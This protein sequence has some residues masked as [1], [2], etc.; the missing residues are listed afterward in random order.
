MLFPRVHFRG[1]ML[2]G[3]PPG[4]LGLANKTGRMNSELFSEVIDHFIHHSKSS[5]DQTSLLVYDNHES[6]LSIEVMDKAKENGVT[7][8]T[9][10]PHSSN[11]MQ[12]LDV[13]VYK[14]FKTYYSQAMDSWMMRN[15]GKP[16]SIY[17]I[18]HCVGIA[19]QKAMTPANITAA[20]RKTGIFPF[21][22][23]IFTEA[24]FLSTA[25]TDRPAPS[26]DDGA[27][28]MPTAVYVAPAG[29]VIPQSNTS[30]SDPI[31]STSNPSTS[32]SN[33]STSTSDPI[34]SASDPSKSTPDN[35]L[36][37]QIFNSPTVFKGYPKAMERKSTGKGRRKGSSL[38]AT[39]TPVKDALEKIR[40]KSKR[41]KPKQSKRSLVLE[42][43]H[44]SEHSD[45]SPQQA[46][47]ARLPKRTK[48]VTNPSKGKSKS[49]VKKPR[50][51]SSSSDDEKWPCIICGEPF[52]DSKSREV[53]V[54]CQLC[55]KIGTRG[56]HPR[57]VFLHLP[58][59]WQREWLSVG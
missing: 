8:L 7:I 20:F 11:K 45:T 15:P 55:K 54:D 34:T 16:I 38:I 29:N 14:P 41:T 46:P 52:E 5:K 33:P 17:E 28:A 32:T 22:K 58:E 42:L 23:T 21:D 12:P 50:M 40:E 57:D 6:H 56:V 26:S 48:R 4:T 25:V 37:P 1:H 39:D 19:H 13:G 2:R 30:T 24:D 49:A 3:A 31:T 27:E 47:K 51:S 9:L 53:W 59:L 44:D 18:A 43:E 35:S 36:A 10:P